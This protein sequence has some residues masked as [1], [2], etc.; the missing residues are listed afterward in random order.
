MEKLLVLH[1]PHMRSSDSTRS[2]MRGVI[3]ALLP[4]V[5]ASAIFFGWDAIRVLIVSVSACVLIE[6]ACQ[7]LLGRPVTV[8]DGSA[9]IT[10][11]LFACCIPPSSP[12]WVIVAGSLCG[13]A[14]TKQIFGGLGYNIF[15]PALVARAVALAA[16][17]I[18]MTTWTAPFDAMTTATP[19]AIVKQKLQIDLPSY[20]D[21]FMGN[22]SGSLGETSALA[23]LIGGAILIMRGI[24]YWEVPVLYISTVFAGSIFVGRDPLFEILAGG[25]FLGAFFMITDM[26][27]SPITRLGCAINAVGAGVLVVLIRNWGGYPEGVC[28]S[29]L[30]MNAFTP[31]IDR[32]V[33]PRILGAK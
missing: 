19:L 14:I 25:L 10:G 2:I 8:D 31:I 33:R 4:V 29:I 30:I 15:N 6:A 11:I 27:T 24:I 26:V 13:I 22:V 9:V 28:Y 7:R 16:F 5:A 17:P 3:I 21:L 18:Q 32:Y 20:W 12:W 1:A 23:I